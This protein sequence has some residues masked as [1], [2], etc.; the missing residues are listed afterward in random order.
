VELVIYGGIVAV[1][2][3]VRSTAL[4][5]AREHETLRLQ[6]E[7][8][9]A[10]LT[11]LRMQLQPHFLFNTLHTIGSLVLQRETQRAVE[12]LSGLGEL[13]RG[14]LAHR[15]NDL[16]PL[17]DE[18]A[19]LRRYLK[20]EEA[21]FSDRLTIRWDIDPAAEEA[22]IPPFILQPVVENAFRHGISRRTDES[23]LGIAA[24]TEQGSVRITV[25][26]DGPPLSHAFAVDR[27]SGY[28]LKNVRERLQTRNPAGRLELANAAAGVRATLLLPRWDSSSA[29]STE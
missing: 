16:V 2:H 24:T 10:K 1:A 23:I 25:Y 5:R 26:N 11:A 22:L 27:A 12:L 15:D 6:A 28:G 3:A 29:R 9:G 19:Y 13:L 7:L 17:R 14:T 18:I 20:I 8:T 21:R 4:L